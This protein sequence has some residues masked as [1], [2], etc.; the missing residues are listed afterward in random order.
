MAAASTIRS[1][2]GGR[3][4]ADFTNRIDANPPVCPLVHVD[5]DSNS[6]FEG[7]IDMNSVLPLVE[8]LIALATKEE[9]EIDALCS[10]VMVRDLER[11]EQIADGL[12]KLRG[13]G[14]S[15]APNH[16]RSRHVDGRK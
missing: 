10:A 13:A 3:L 12:T 8:R 7:A 9:N 2:V 15:S 4:I 16:V 5:Q 11:A 6:S 1:K 14:K